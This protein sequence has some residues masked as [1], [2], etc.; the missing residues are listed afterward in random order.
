SRLTGD[1]EAPGE[2]AFDGRGELA[3]QPGVP[4]EQ[5]P[6]D[7]EILEAIEAQ[8][9]WMT[10]ILARL[11]RT[12]TTLGNEEAGQAVMRSTLREDLHLEPVDVPMDAEALRAHPQSAPFDWSLE[13]RSNVVAI[14]GPD[15]SEEIS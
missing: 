10:E 9:D 8:G 2:Y 15:G 14:W 12:Q 13:G 7:S 4:P 5:A 3:T 11:V 6:E 1:L